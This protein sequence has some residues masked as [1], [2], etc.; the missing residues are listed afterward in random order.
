MKKKMPCNHHASVSAEVEKQWGQLWKVPTHDHKK[1]LTNFS[2]PDT[3]KKAQ[4]NIK[5]FK[6][7]KQFFNTPNSSRSHFVH[8]CKLH[9]VI[10]ETSGLQL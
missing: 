2:R 10:C 3:N 4:V 8:H 9:Y 1:I 7:K 5:N 6:R